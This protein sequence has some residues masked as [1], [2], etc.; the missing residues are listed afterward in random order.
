MFTPGPS[1]AAIGTSPGRIFGESISLV[2]PSVCA[3]QRGPYALRSRLQ[4]A[5]SGAG[6]DGVTSLRRWRVSCDD[7]K[8]EHEDNAQGTRSGCARLSAR[9]HGTAVEPS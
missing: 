9:T 1:T 6:G 3:G 2:V 8:H 5:N 7:A 4:L